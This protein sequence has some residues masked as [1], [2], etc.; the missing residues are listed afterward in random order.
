MHEDGRVSRCPVLSRPPCVWQ[1]RPGL[2]RKRWRW[3]RGPG[4]ECERL[5]RGRG[6]LF[7]RRAC[8]SKFNEYRDM[9]SGFVGELNLK[10]EKKDSAVLLRASGEESGEGRP[11]V[12]G[13]R[14]AAT[15]C[16][17]GSGMGSHS[18]RVEQQ[19]PDDLS[20]ERGTPS[21]CPRRFATPS[22]P[23]KSLPGHTPQIAAGSIQGHLLKA[24]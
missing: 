24:I 5:G 9:D 16:P 15:A 17:P 4:L 6:H 20:R 8:S 21:P 23:L 18:A 3:H 10:A 14:S 11:V 22:L 13:R 19:R 7:S 1:F 2:G 12:R